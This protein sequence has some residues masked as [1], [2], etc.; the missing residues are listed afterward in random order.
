MLLGLIKMSKRIGKGTC[1]KASI[2]MVL[3][4]FCIGVVFFFFREGIVF[5]DN[6]FN[7]DENFLYKVCLGLFLLLSV[8]VAFRLLFLS[9]KI[10]GLS[11]KI[12]NGLKTN[13]NCISEIMERFGGIFYSIW[14][15]YAQ[16]FSKMKNSAGTR[17]TR[18]DADLYFN[19]EDIANKSF[20][21]LPALEL[22]KG[23][24]GAFIGLGIL[25]TF[26]GFTN[27]IP[28]SSHFSSIDELKPLLSGL[29]VAFN[30]SIFGILSS[31]IYTFFIAQPITHSLENNTREL[32]DL[33][34]SDHYISDVEV[35]RRGLEDFEKLIKGFQNDYVQKIIAVTTEL[36]KITERLKDT[37]FEIE[38]INK[39]LKA[40]AENIYEVT[41]RQL[42]SVFS[43][44]KKTISAMNK[45]HTHFDETASIVRESCNDI[46]SIP[47]NVAQIVSDLLKEVLENSFNEVKIRISEGTSELEQ[48]TKEN[49]SQSFGGFGQ[50][51]VEKVEVLTNELISSNR[52][53]IEQNNK[54][55]LD[56]IEGIASSISSFEKNIV[57]ISD[58]T[59][60]IPGEITKIY[61]DLSL[62]PSK[63]EKLQDEFMTSSE[64]LVNSSG[65]AD[66]IGK[67]KE[68]NDGLTRREL[69]LQGLMNRSGDKFKD[70]IESVES[71]AA[72]MEKISE[73]ME[74]ARAKID[75]SNTAMTLRM[76]KLLECKSNEEIKIILEKILSIAEQMNQNQ[77]MVE[78]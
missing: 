4:F 6:S 26:I 78:Q 15:S 18:S 57:S 36:S 20:F 49:I 61:D 45:V 28:E 37:P 47:N 63:L 52:T 76:R 11:K 22:L 73:R 64:Q 2:F 1:L 21:G 35:S 16:T 71:V 39:R 48:F 32:S 38:E 58:S 42:D 53:L 29:K 24:P 54:L 74:S 34:D 67:I 13:N 27:A 62:I 43:T 12:V 14:Q 9:Y 5:K 66:A 55:L 8:L 33:I 51:L 65:L 70:A 75:S 10:N 7:L 23:I 31:V 44:I 46:R 25:G 56:E 40:N 17:E 3:G 60:L 72:T 69:T 77:G 30:T 59:E 50:F 19:A 68:L 41:S